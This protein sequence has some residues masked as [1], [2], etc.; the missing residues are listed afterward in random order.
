MAFSLL[1]SPP[2]VPILVTSSCSNADGGSCSYDVSFASMLPEAALRTTAGAS[3]MS[4]AHSVL[5]VVS[6]ALVVL[7]GCAARVVP[8]AGL[9]GVF[10]LV[11]N[12]SL[13]VTNCK[14][15]NAIRQ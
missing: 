7:G 2:V 9:Y 3:W 1:K 13:W 12:R 10:A 15:E 14:G 11:S 4:S 6:V 5:S 8:T